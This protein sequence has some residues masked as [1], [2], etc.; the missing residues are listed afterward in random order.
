MRN[1]KEL[2]QLMLDNQYLFDNGL[3][4]W[5]FNLRWSDFN[6]PI[7]NQKESDLLETYIEKNRP[8]P[9]SSLNALLNFTNTYYWKKSDIK[10][11]I[12]WIEK[13]IRLNS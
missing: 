4:R 5:R 9:L 3:C 12:K 1:I 7:I 2:L 6:N 13:H 10:P 11:R 8:H